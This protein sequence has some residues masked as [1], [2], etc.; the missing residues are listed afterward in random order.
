[1]FILPLVQVK[2]SIKKPSVIQN[3]S[4]SVRTL[5]MVQMTGLEPA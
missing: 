2:K 3:L 1:M 4:S 5:G